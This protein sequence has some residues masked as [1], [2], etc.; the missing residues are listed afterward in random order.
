MLNILCW[1][2]AIS[3]SLAI[4]GGVHWRKIVQMSYVQTVICPDWNLKTRIVELKLGQLI[5][6]WIRDL[7]IEK[8]SRKYALEA[9]SSPYLISVN[10]LTQ[11]TSNKLIFGKKIL[12]GDYWKTS[13]N[14]ISFIELSLFWWA[15]LAKISGLELVTSLLLTFQI[16]LK[17][18][19]TKTFT[20][21]LA[22]ML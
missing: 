15:L 12:Y 18:F 5:K 16:C 7:V 19:Y 3:L 2:L 14:I 6:Y 21:W 4:T 13:Q 1:P 8:S 17:I 11:Q 22:L 20:T 9:S 10:N